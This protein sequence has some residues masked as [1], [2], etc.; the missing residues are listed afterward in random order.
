MD[1]AT[2]AVGSAR[3]RYYKGGSY[4]RQLPRIV[5]VNGENGAR[6]WACPNAQVKVEVVTW[7]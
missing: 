3:V 4:D 2:N 5:S 6:I 1:V 7:A